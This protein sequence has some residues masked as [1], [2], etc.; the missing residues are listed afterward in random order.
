MIMHD[1]NSFAHGHWDVLLLFGGLNHCS[2]LQLLTPRIMPIASLELNVAMEAFGALQL[3][4]LS[5]ML[6]CKTGE[7]L[8]HIISYS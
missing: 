1:M 7:D 5:L 4:S 2:C 6:F 8:A 3:S